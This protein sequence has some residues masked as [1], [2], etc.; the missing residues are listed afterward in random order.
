MIIPTSQAT[1]CHAMRVMSSSRARSRWFSWTSRTSLMVLCWKPISLNWARRRRNSAACNRVQQS[2]IHQ[3]DSNSV[4]VTVFASMLTHF[5]EHRHQSHLL[6][7]PHLALTVLEH[8]QGFV[9]LGFVETQLTQTISGPQ[10]FQDLP[11]TTQSRFILIFVSFFLFLFL[12]Q[13]KTQQSTKISLLLWRRL[14]VPYQTTK[15]QAFPD[16][17]IWICKFGKQLSCIRFHFLK[18]WF[19]ISRYFLQKVPIL[20]FFCTLFSWGLC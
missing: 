10:V 5:D 4:P 20:Y 15:Y 12:N 1:D 9:H 7:R 17:N 13:W 14:F 2:Y 3:S 19:L 16:L 11:A 18:N 6:E 8:L